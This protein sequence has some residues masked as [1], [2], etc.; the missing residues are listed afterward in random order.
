MKF[1]HVSQKFSVYF[2]ICT[3]I[4]LSGMENRDAVGKE[5]FMVFEPLDQGPIC[6]VQR[7]DGSFVE[8]NV[9]TRVVTDPIH[10]TSVRFTP[11]E[12]KIIGVLY[13]A[14]GRIVPREAFISEIWDSD[15]TDWTTRTVD[16]H[17]SAIRKK[18]MV[19]RGL[20]ID[21]VYGKG[22]KLVILSRF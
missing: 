18:L 5:D 7:G 3:Y 19:V 10:K 11:I 4:R 15:N 16:V 9:D 1:H 14:K 12:W 2:Y 21:S 20:R 22:Y 6:R 13:D 8:V 17:I